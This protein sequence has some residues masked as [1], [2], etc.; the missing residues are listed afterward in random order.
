MSYEQW[1]HTIYMPYMND[2]LER[3]AQYEAEV[4]AWNQAQMEA[5]IVTNPLGDVTNSWKNPYYDYSRKAYGNFLHEQVIGNDPK[6]EFSQEYGK[7]KCEL[8]STKSTTLPTKIAIGQQCW[9]NTSNKC[10]EH[11]LSGDCD[12]GELTTEK[13]KCELLSTK[14]GLP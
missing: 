9:H 4:A 6:T 11:A 3:V 7:W 5:S 13:W 8:L 14:G 1:Y 10:V 12:E 2:Y